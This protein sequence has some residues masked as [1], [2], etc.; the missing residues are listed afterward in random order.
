MVDGRIIPLTLPINDTGFDKL[1]E[2]GVMAIQ[3]II[4][5]GI[6]V[7]F[8]SELVAKVVKIRFLVGS[9]HQPLVI[10][11]ELLI[12]EILIG[13]IKLNKLNQKMLLNDM[14]AER[15]GVL[16]ALVK[17]DKITA[18]GNIEFVCC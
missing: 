1:I 5:V 8:L 15:E 7:V 17:R 2:N 13:A 10:V 12:V 3:Q 4:I 18:G 11:V 9:I 6:V 16:L 14:A